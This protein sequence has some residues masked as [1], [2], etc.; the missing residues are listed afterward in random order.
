MEMKLLHHHLDESTPPS[1]TPTPDQN[2][3]MTKKDG[4]EAS[5]SS[6]EDELDESTPLS[7]TPT[8]D[9]NDNMIKKI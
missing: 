2:D 5:P 1:S 8:P 7:S 9:Q 4:N 3:K 6:H